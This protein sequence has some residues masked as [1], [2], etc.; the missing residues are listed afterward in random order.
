[1]T[2][3]IQWRRG[4]TAEHSSFTG[5]NGEITIDTTKKTAIVHDEATVS[6]F[7]LARED[8]SNVPDASLSSRGL[9]LADMTNVSVGAVADLGIAKTDLSNVSADATETEKGQVEF[10]TISET[11]TGTNTTLATTPAGVKS[12]IALPTMF[13]QGLILENDTDAEHDIKINVGKT[14]SADDTTDIS[15]ASVI[16]RQIDASWTAGNNA[17]GMPSPLTVSANMTYHLF[18]IMKL[19]GTIDVGFDTSL[20]A[21]NL[22]SDA[23]DFVKYRRIGSVIT[24]ASANIV[25]FTAYETAGGAVDVMYSS[26][27]TD[28][29][30]NTSLVLVDVSI[31]K[32]IYAKGLFQAK[33]QTNGGGAETHLANYDGSQQTA[34]VAYG[35]EAE[36]TRSLYVGDDSQIKLAL[37]GT[38]ARQMITLGFTDTRK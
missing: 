23:T 29:T 26:N 33:A 2:K 18:V 15:L 32:G 9:A 7:P 11:I 30:A 38:S 28:Y 13:I 6:G 8:L 10:A 31:P 37:S 4:T 3:A 16:T 20:T 27:I 19:D 25:G 36:Q 35:G 5:L 14:R 1:M 34:F 22:L 24:D 17:G 12:L 21:T